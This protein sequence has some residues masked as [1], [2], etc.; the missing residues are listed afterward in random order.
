MIEGKGANQVLNQVKRQTSMQTAKLFKKVQ[1]KICRS[2]RIRGI[3][4]LLLIHRFLS[5]LIKM[6]YKHQHPDDSQSDQQPCVQYARW[7][8]H[9]QALFQEQ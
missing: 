5:Q 7:I 9:M 1:D 4:G 3:L 2:W 6:P 8:S